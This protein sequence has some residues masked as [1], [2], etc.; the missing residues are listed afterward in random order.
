MKIASR[1]IYQVFFFFLSTKKDVSEK[2]V[3][4]MFCTSFG[5][6]MRV[7]VGRDSLDWHYRYVASLD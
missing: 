1:I 7:L 6:T 5:F 3:N 4:F 2:V